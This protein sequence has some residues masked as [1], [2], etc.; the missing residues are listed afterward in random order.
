MTILFLLTVTAVIAPFVL[1]A[2]TSLELASDTLRKD[3]LD[4]LADGLLTVLAR[5]LAFPPADRG[6]APPAPRSV[7]TSCSAGGLSIEA[8]VQ[9]QRGLVDLNAAGPDLL[10]AALRSLGLPPAA[11]AGNAAAMVAYRRPRDA[12]DEVDPAEDALVLDG[13]KRAPFEAV[14]EVYDFVALQGLPLARV[15]ETFTIHSQQPEILGASMPHGL[16]AVV[17]ERPAPPPPSGAAE[18]TGAVI[19][20]I[21]VRVRAEDATLGYAGA[22]VAAAGSADGAFTVVERVVDPAILPGAGTAPAD[23]T[24]CAALFGPQVAAALRD[25]TG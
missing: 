18:A 21:E 5:D 4:L 3:R 15:T 19:F 14:E 16:A 12:S 23:A 25:F 1:A 6:R 10:E 24:S 7:P 17:P 22:I 20:R 8:R 11:A 13:L 2:R 9:D